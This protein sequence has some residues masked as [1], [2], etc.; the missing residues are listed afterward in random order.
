MAVLICTVCLILVRL[1]F[2]NYI[3][4]IIMITYDCVNGVLLFSAGVVRKCDIFTDASGKSKV[5]HNHCIQFVWKI[6]HIFLLSCLCGDG[7]L[8][9]V[10]GNGVSSVLVQFLLT[11]EYI[12]M[13]GVAGKS[14]G[15]LQQ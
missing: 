3:V 6:M 11:G 12:S 8:Y 9:R 13:I 14:C 7:C 5:H 4:I 10:L 1:I 2:T 15:F